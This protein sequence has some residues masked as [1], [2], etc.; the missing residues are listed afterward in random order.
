MVIRDTISQG[1]KDF[2]DKITNLDPALIE[3]Q[4]ELVAA[5]ELRFDTKT[6][7]DGSKWEAS[8]KFDFNAKGF[9][10]NLDQTLIGDRR[11]KSPGNFGKRTEES[12]P[13]LRDSIEGRVEGNKVFHG[14]NVSY[15]KEVQDGK[16]SG[17]FGPQ[18]PR[19]FL[20]FSEDSKKTILEIFE[21]HLG[22]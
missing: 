20:G 17:R 21:D 5:A 2:F 19:P 14:S 3:I 1:L 11:K 7:P 8:Y 22:G 16:S 15:A 13:R 4:D 10:K 9:V 6:A 12:G 18:P